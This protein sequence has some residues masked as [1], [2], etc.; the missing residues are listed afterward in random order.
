MR[1]INIKTEYLKNPL[2]IDALHPVLTWN[3]EG[4]DIRFQK[5]FE[6]HYRINNCI[7]YF[8]FINK[9]H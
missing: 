2:G 6:I 3:L 7:F 1:I 8:I 9:I 5:A 4:E